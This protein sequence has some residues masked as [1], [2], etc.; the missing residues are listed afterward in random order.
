VIRLINRRFVP[1]YFDL[2]PGG[3]LADPQARKFTVDACPDLGGAGVDTPL[4]RRD[5]GRRS[6]RRG[7][8]LRQ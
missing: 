6:A 1:I 2:N 8:Q 4:P 7:Q 5:S 3:A